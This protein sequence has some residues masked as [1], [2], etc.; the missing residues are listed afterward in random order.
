MYIPITSPPCSLFFQDIILTSGCSASL[1][2]AITGLANAGENIL[3]PKPGFSI[4]KTLAESV[5]IECRSYTLMV[6]FGFTG[7]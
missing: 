7:F 3:V 5:D 2:M 6:S 4:Y 1:E